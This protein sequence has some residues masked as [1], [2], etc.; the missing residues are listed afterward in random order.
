MRADL[1]LVVSPV[2]KA[3]LDAECFETDVRI[4]PTIYSLEDGDPPGFASSTRH[5]F[6][7]RFRP[8]TER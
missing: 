4:I 3:I 2:E 1:T 6:H 5:R 7:R 8:R